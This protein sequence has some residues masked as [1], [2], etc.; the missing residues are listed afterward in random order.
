MTDLQW[1]NK[2][3]EHPGTKYEIEIPAIVQDLEAQK[4]FINNID[5][6]KD[7]TLVDPTANLLKRVLTYTD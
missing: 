3:G 6:E 1:Y 5:L 2:H 4:K 7:I